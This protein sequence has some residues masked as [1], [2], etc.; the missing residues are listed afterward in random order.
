MSTIIMA[1]M[2]YFM[3]CMHGI[4]FIGNPYWPVYLACFICSSLRECIRLTFL[5][6]FMNH[7]YL[8]FYYSLISMFWVTDY[9]RHDG[10][11]LLRNLENFL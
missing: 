4:N 3:N 1:G 7:M 6:H 5:S 9:D 8:S 2:K 10:F 11:I